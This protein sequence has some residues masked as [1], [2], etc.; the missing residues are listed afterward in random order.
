MSPSDNFIIFPNPPLRVNPNFLWPCWLVYR[1]SSLQC[2]M[3]APLGQTSKRG[4]KRPRNDYS[5]A[6]HVCVHE[7]ACSPAQGWDQ[8]CF[9]GSPFLLIISCRLL[10][11]ARGCRCENK[12]LDRLRYWQL[13]FDARCPTHCRHCTNPSVNLPLCYS[14]LLLDLLHPR[15]Q[16]SPELGAS[17]FRSRGLG[18]GVGVTLFDLQLT[19]GS[20][21]V[22]RSATA[23]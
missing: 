16:L 22:D 23:T 10:P 5:A 20:F 4:E 14:L 9:R 12:N 21:A 11:T 3:P 15:Q 8:T 13:Y 1:D 19:V 6:A 2:T 17:C 18:L 7:R